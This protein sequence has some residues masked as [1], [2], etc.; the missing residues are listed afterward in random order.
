[1]DLLAAHRPARDELQTLLSR[2]EELF[3]SS[4]T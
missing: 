3:E 4:G 2:W 1:M